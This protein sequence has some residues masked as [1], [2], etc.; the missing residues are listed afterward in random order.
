MID[1]S[2]D[3]RRDRNRKKRF[4]L[5]DLLLSDASDEEPFD[6]SESLG[7][8]AS[9]SF[10][11]SDW[12][13]NLQKEENLERQRQDLNK[14]RGSDRPQH[15]PSMQTIQSNRDTQRAL[16]SDSSGVESSDGSI[17]LVSSES[18]C[19][20]DSDSSWDPQKRKVFL[21]RNRDANRR[22]GDDRTD[23]EVAVQS[24]LDANRRRGDDRTDHEVAA[25]S[26]RDANRRRGDDRTDHEVAVQ[27]NLNSKREKK[28][29][30]VEYNQYSQ[31]P[32]SRAQC[33]DSGRVECCWGVLCFT[34]T[35]T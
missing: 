5:Q 26:N 33:E 19:L 24:N 14:R 32:P 13:C 27:S 35:P 9:E 3:E 31:Q 22:R 18:H 12:S 16:V 34:T 17:S 28:P 20:Q 1:S 10:Q 7:F 11:D 23:N 8:S 21:Q 15:K 29:I 6:D 2:D 25:Q 30:P 4:D